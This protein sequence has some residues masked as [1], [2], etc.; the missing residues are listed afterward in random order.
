VPGTVIV[1]DEL[2]PWDNPEH[3][4]LWAEGEFRALGEWLAEHDRAF[5][6]LL[7]SSHQQC[8][9]KIER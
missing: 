7:R 6:T 5:R 4:D 3:Y 9:I 1:F 8:S 2:Y